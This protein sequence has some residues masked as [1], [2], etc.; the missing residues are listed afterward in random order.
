MQREINLRVKYRE[1][2][3][4]F[5][6]V[7]L[8][9]KKSEWFDIQTDSPYMLIVSSVNNK[10]LLLDSKTRLFNFED[11]NIKRSIIP[12]VTHVDCS[13]RI[14]TVSFNQNPLLYDLISNFN[15]LTNCPILIN[16]SFNVRGEPIVQTPDDAYKCFMRTKIHY[17]FL[18]KFLIDKNQ[19]I[20]KFDNPEE[21][22]NKLFPLD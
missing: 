20:Y 8:D 11:L 4:P 14:Q 13:A 19:E 15:K 22:I 5:A 1:S 12:A 18:G 17:L 3:R 9:N 2:F 21:D 6:P 7:I 16:T 10:K